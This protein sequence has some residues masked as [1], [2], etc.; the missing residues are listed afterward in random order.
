MGVRETEIKKASWV[1]ILGNAFLSILKIVIGFISGSLAVVGDGIDSASDIIISIIT[2]ITARIIS[3]PPDIKHPYGYERADTIASK[4]LSFIIFFAG[5]QLAIS[6]I[7]K[8]IEKTPQEIPS[9][10]AIYV[11]IIS[12][13][14]KLLLA[15][16][17]FKIGKKTKSS[18]LLANAKNMQNDVIISVAVL[19]GLIFTF[20]LKIPSFDTIIALAVSVWIMFTA[21]KIF[22]QS[23][24][25]LMDGVK[26]PTIYNKIFEAVSEVKGVYNPHKVRLRKIGYNYIIEI[27][28]EVDGNLSVNESHKIA[29]L[30]E[31]SIKHKI[32]NVYDILIHIEPYGSIDKDEKYGVSDKDLVGM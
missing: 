14:G 23:N 25:E 32:E 16:Y 3:K 6:T 19:V 31:K 15:L 8:L 20:V 28:I 29:H 9:I 5:I 30:V 22:M 10:I 26:D 24:I 12:I 21:Y 4:A 13:I 1:S 27:D 7:S 2:L 18:M 11:T 17:Q